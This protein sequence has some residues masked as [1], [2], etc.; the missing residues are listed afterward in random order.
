MNY[1]Y[2]IDAVNELYPDTTFNGIE[3][4]RD[5]RYFWPDIK[6]EDWP[7]HKRDPV[8]IRQYKK[9]P[10]NTLKED[11]VS[12]TPTVETWA[13]KQLLEKHVYT[14]TTDGADP[15]GVHDK[16]VY[17]WRYEAL[18]DILG[19]KVDGEGN[20]T[21]VV[22]NIYKAK[23]KK[24]ICYITLPSKIPQENPRTKFLGIESFP[25]QLQY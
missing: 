19:I 3:P 9:E 22:P 5:I 2:Y 6:E 23:I 15:N 7:G 16:Y 4:S 8:D 20:N 13:Y 21:T 14:T 12:K 11:P 24:G 25:F 18:E 1:N 10:G 17:W